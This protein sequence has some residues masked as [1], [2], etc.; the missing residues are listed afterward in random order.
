[1]LEY[2]IISFKTEE[3]IFA[4]VQDIEGMD[5]CL[6]DGETEEDAIKEA[7]LV[8]LDILDDYTS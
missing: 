3:G 5:I 4:K 1:M 8:F 2:K 7:C 6:A